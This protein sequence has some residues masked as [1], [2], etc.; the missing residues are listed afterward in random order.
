MLLPWNSKNI[1]NTK[2][3]NQKITNVNMETQI[4]S[5]NKLL[6]DTKSFTSFIKDVIDFEAKEIFPDILKLSRMDFFDKLKS[7][8]VVILSKKFT[9]KIFEME[10]CTSILTK[11]L[12]EY[13]STYK[14]Y[15]EE[16]NNAWDKYQTEIIN[17]RINDENINIEDNKNYL[18]H[19]RKHCIK[20]GNIAIHKCNKN[21][22]G[23]YV[24]V[25]EITN[26]SRFKNT[27]IKYVICEN[28]HKTYFIN[29]FENYCES[30]D[31][32][33]F[34]S[35][36]EKNENENLLP[37]T[38]ESPHC[39]NFFN[40]KL[41]CEKCNGIFYIN[42]LTE[43]L[44]CMNMRCG[45]KK[46]INDQKKWKCKVCNEKFSSKIIIY[47][48][49]EVKNFKL[50]I[51]KALIYQIKAHP[52]K[53]S[54]SKNC[55]KINVNSLE[56][57]HKKNCDGILYFAEY[58][59]KKI[60]ICK[61][62][63]AINMCK[64]FIWIC[65]ICGTHFRDTKYDE[66]EELKIRKTKSSTKFG[67]DSF[68]QSN[69]QYNGN[70]YKKSLADLMLKKQK[71]EKEK[72]SKS[73]D[74]T[75]SKRNRFTAKTKDS[76][77][78]NKEDENNDIKIN[79]R[80]R[81]IFNKFIR[82]H[83]NST[84][85]GYCS[86]KNTIESEQNDIEN[87]EK[88]TNRKKKN[89]YNKKVD[90]IISTSGQKPIMQ[91]LSNNKIN[92]R[93]IRSKLKNN[94]ENT[95]SNDEILKKNKNKLFEKEEERS[96]QIKSKDAIRDTKE[97]KNEKEENKVKK[98]KIL[99]Y[100]HEKEYKKEK[101]EKINQN[102]KINNNVIESWK[103]RDTT[104]K[105]SNGS[106]KSESSN[107]NNNEKKNK[108]LE[109][110][111][112]PEFIDYFNEDIEIE[113]EKIIENEK[114]YNHIQR[115]LKKVLA[116]GNLPRFNMDNYTIVKKIGDGAFGSIYEIY[117][118]KTKIKYAIKEIIANNIVSLE[119]F[120]KEFEI[121]YQNPHE[122]IL[123]IYGI[124][125]KCINQNNFILYVLMD[126]AD[127][128]WEV[129]ITQRAKK[130]QYYSEDELI[131][132]LKQVYK[133]LTFLQQ[134][135]QIAHRDIKAENILIFNNNGKKE[136]KICDFGEAKE[137]KFS[138]KHKTLRGTELY[139]SP[140]LY[141]GLLHDEQFVEHDAFKSDVFSLGCCMIIA[142]VLDFDIINK[143]RE[144][145]E[146]IKIKKFL[147]NKFE[148]RYSNKFIDIVLKM[149]NFNEKERID[150]VEL[151]QIIKKEF[152]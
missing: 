23:Y 46:E 113:D 135:K 25:N 105:G 65:P 72:E 2:E 68:Y 129:E 81:Y 4:E 138:K 34:C 128:D 31:K 148:G 70:K 134:E 44:E 22:S 43:K 85:I 66:N 103:S 8:I 78:E 137:T 7:N 114:L 67:I 84:K 152:P 111:I 131:Y 47:N 80:R 76:I 61:K 53:L 110:V 59:D 75:K 24:I 118:N 95:K 18:T 144:L 62:C 112:E 119:G 10:N 120:Q 145:K 37:A 3:N 6:E 127:L 40:Q 115:R 60:I 73:E 12:H 77:T 98:E 142:G 19:F 56:F 79:E 89:F 9:K 13:E 124:C 1:F 28:C 136:Y 15:T 5:L 117:N 121:V 108:N 52:T 83:I 141:N 99:R 149:M 26:S 147:K 30:C 139:M 106:K 151:D 17:K 39:D 29:S 21:E 90:E 101:N 48:P 33:Y 130:K 27:K 41:L 93:Q 11:C 42:L 146:Q 97:N 94:F 116:K 63:L 92:S 150:F 16:L 96:R 51:K 55:K 20:T 132:I 54:C 91:Y 122:N 71:K 35:P 87:T 88:E 58:D 123:D 140:L 143:I 32:T 14:N 45:Y 104:S 82:G 133:P 36:L 100:Y 126:L 69:L 86:Q 125:V 49:V 109:D 102:N 107:D 38:L 64:R 57:Y 50:L 74:E